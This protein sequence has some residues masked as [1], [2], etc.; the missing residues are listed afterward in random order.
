MSGLNQWL[1][2]VITLVICLVSG[3][4]AHPDTT[5]IVGAT[6]HHPPSGTGP[7]PLVNVIARNHLED[8]EALLSKFR[9]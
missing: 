1:E 8:V 3:L 6:V 9:I 7:S 2:L 4:L 5:V